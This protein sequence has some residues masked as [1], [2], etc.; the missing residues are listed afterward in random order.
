MIWDPCWLYV[1]PIQ[2]ELGSVTLH[3][4]YAI[5]LMLCHMRRFT[6]RARSGLCSCTSRFIA[7]PTGRTGFP[8]SHVLNVSKCLI[9]WPMRKCLIHCF[10][11]CLHAHTFCLHHILRRGPFQ[12]RH[13]AFKQFFSSGLMMFS[14]HDSNIFQHFSNMF[15]TSSNLSSYPRD[16]SRLISGCISSNAFSSES[17][18]GTRGQRPAALLRCSRRWAS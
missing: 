2:T 4:P 18:S 8:V 10:K 11:L 9:S 3:K 16:L 6:K 7:P 15:P 1:S 12:K 17:N 14:L 5:H 13:K